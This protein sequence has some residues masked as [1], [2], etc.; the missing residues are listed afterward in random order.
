MFPDVTELI[1]KFERGFAECRFI[2]A[3]F[4]EN[5]V[6]LET[7]HQTQSGSTLDAVSGNAVP[8]EDRGLNFRKAP[9][10]PHDANVLFDYV[11]FQGT[12]RSNL[13]EQICAKCFKFLPRLAR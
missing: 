4:T 6:R 13:V 5:I 3:D 1:Q 7:A 8:R 10:P 12:A 9:Q 11:F 2:S